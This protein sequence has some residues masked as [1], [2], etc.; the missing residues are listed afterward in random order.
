MYYLPLATPAG[1]LPLLEVNGQTISES[2]TIARF[3]ARE[4]DLGGKT[5]WE[6]ARA[7]MVGECAADTLAG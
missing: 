7:D 2:M 3:L 5:S 4:F 1:H 6:Q